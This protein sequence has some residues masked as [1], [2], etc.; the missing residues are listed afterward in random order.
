MGDTRLLRGAG[1]WW[2]VSNMRARRAT[3]QEARR[4]SS[5]FLPRTTHLLSRASRAMSVI[6]SLPK[7]NVTREREREMSTSFGAEDGRLRRAEGFIAFASSLK[8][9]S[10]KR[11]S[12]TSTQ[13]CCAT[14]PDS[15]MRKPPTLDKKRRQNP[16][17]DR[18]GG[19][20]HEKHLERKE[21]RQSYARQSLPAPAT[22]NITKPR[23]L[24]RRCRDCCCCSCVS[25]R[26][27]HRPRHSSRTRAPTPW[28]TAAEPAPRRASQCP[29]ECARRHRCQC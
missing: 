23:N 12:M 22:L 16:Q 10:E 1:P 25:T 20:E 27:H 13:S 19:N 6:F 4:R 28:Q 3:T 7:P 8:R 5:C 26:C 17:G 21:N 9:S 29:P 14:V 18:D 2:L 11:G 15:V 24:S